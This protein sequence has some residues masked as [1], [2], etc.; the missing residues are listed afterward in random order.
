M[1]QFQ[2]FKLTYAFNHAEFITAT[3][4]K[5]VNKVW[6]KTLCSLLPAEKRYKSRPNIKWLV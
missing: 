5:I 3:T 6:H 1:V 2:S 4:Y